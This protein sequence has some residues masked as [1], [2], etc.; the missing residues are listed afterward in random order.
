MG[1][2]AGWSECLGTS[3]MAGEG[4]VDESFSPGG[5]G[6]SLLLETLGGALALP[7]KELRPEWPGRGLLQKGSWL[8]LSIPLGQPP[9]NAERLSNDPPALT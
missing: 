4:T 7:S 6:D 8:G 2:G 1:R 5:T 3:I 9:Q